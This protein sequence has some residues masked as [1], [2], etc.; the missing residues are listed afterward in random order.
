MAG[1]HL[2]VLEADFFELD[3]GVIN[4]EAAAHN[5]AQLLQDLVP[6]LLSA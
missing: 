2:L 4:S 5:G 1:T 6:F 3:G